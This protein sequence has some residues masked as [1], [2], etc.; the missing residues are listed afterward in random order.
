MASAA[1]TSDPIDIPKAVAKLRDTFNRGRTKPAH[2]RVQQLER[3]A[4]MLRERERAFL[5]ALHQDLRKSDMEAWVAEVGFLQR[6]LRHAL[7]QIGAWMRPEKI[8]TPLILQPGSAAIHREPYGVVLV[9]G[10]WNFPVLLSLSPMIGAIAAGNCVLLKPSELAPAASRVI[11]DAV[12][13]YLD[14]DAVQVIEGGIP[15]ST[16]L[17]EQRF[18]HIFFT[19]GTA[20]GRIVM[21]AAAKHLT[22]VTLELGGKSPCLVDKDVNMEVAV[23]RILMTKFTNCGQMCIAPDYILVHRDRERE[24]LETLEKTITDFF[25]RDPKASKDL[26]RVINARHF[27]RLTALLDSGK[28]VI[29]GETDAE[30][31]Y[32]APTV[33]TDVAPDAPV[34]Q[35]EIFGP[36]LP[37]LP[38]ADLDEAIRFVNDKPKPLVLYLFTKDK[39][40]MRRVRERTSSGDMVINDTFSYQLVPD[41]PFGGVGESGIGAYHGRHSFETFSHRRGVLT[42]SLRGDVRKIYPP[43]DASALKWAKRFL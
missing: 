20:V 37:V 35:E 21:T 34:M 36:I 5:D 2:W 25:G 32:I 43:Y 10:P 16:R 38:V 14:N 28:I 12:T 33:L 15:E 41:I 6:E 13:T 30:Q 11:A 24:L 7:K 27:E 42:R 17:L 40:A 9:I 31:R 22:P 18:D 3:F 29:G 1:K 19:G 8:S 4:T 26:A 39:V 23:R